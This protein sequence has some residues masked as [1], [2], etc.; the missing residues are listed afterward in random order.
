[1]SSPYGSQKRLLLG[2][3]P[4]NYWSFEFAG[5]YHA[6]LFSYYTN[7]AYRH[8]NFVETVPFAIIMMAA[9]EYQQTV[10][11]IVIFAMASAL[12]IGRCSHAYAFSFEHKPNIHMRY[13]FPGM[14][15]TIGFIAASS[16]MLLFD[17]VKAFL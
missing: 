16:L 2:Q 11:E 4:A 14:V 1:M 6:A 5:L 15:A 10:P 13:R 3:A 7:C 12:L 8:A 17:G 9:L